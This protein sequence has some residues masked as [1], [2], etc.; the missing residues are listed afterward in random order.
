MNDRP[1]ISVVQRASWVELRPRYLGH[2]RRGTRTR[3]VLYRTTRDR[4]NDSPDRVKF[5]VGRN[6]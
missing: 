6:R 3:N 2:P 1:T 5:P 4:F